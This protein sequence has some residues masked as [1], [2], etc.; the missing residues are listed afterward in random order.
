MLRLKKAAKIT[1]QSAWLELVSKFGDVD[2]L[3][4]SHSSFG[5]PCGNWK[6]G[7]ETDCLMPPTKSRG[8]QLSFKNGH[9]WLGVGDMSYLSS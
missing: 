8:F 9:R 4:L 1:G 6:Q 2:S 5:E 7:L 3:G